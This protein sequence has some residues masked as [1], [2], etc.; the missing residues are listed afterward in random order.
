MRV[1]VV[2]ERED[3]RQQATSALTLRDVEVTEASTSRHA[4]EL[5]V[6]EEFDV[7]VIDG[8]MSPKGGFSLLYEIREGGELRGLTTPPALV[9][10]AREQDRWLAAWAGANEVLK[11]PVDPF[12][13]ANRVAGLADAEAPPAGARESRDQVDAILS[14]TGRDPAAVRDESPGSTAS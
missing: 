2:S 8:D 3:V 10:M 9:M 14:E 5:V 12:E 11:K 1:L 4:R 13:L 7:L 6:Q